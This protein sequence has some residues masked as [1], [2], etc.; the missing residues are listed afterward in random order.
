MGTAL[1]KSLKDIAL[2]LK[3]LQGYDVF[4][5]AG[6]DTHGVPIEFQVEKE[7][8]STGKK[9]IE[10]YGVKK[11]VERCKEFATKHIDVMGDEFKN[12]GVWMD[13][14]NP[15]LTLSD[16]YV[17]T[18]WA[19]FKEADKKGLLYLGKYPVHVCPRCETAVAYNE[20]EY[21]KQ[22]DESIFVKFP[23]KNKK[24]TF[25]IIWTTTP[26]TLPANTGVMVHPNVDYQEVEVAEGE[27]WIIAKDLVPKIM[28]VLERG[29]TTKEE[30]KG[31]KMEGWK[32]ENPLAKNMKLK[33]KK[34]YE[35]VLSARYVT[36]E[37][38][39][40]LVHCAPGHGKEDYEVGKEYGLDMP[41]PVGNNGLL[42]EETG[43]YSGKKAREVDKEIIADLESEGYLVYKVHYD[44]DYPLCWRDKSPLLMMSQPQWFLKI[45]D[46]QKKILK[47]NEKIN[48]VPDW[49]II[50]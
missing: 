46:I 50:R 8:G 15:Y 18:I 11:F 9:D 41:S 19:A 38:G 43:K 33:I 2:R 21:G 47:E 24:N 12:L 20:I 7:I 5:R 4:D 13:F 31:K 45:S 22:R 32:Y 27:R 34:G 44:H 48:W 17:E 36:T 1:N 14:E 37:D 35:V 30:F 16:D 28:G 6:Y 26:W 42:T 23:L 39:T 49:K 40:G 29:F 10:K 25:L 3:R